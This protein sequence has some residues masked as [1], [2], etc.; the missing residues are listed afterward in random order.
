MKYV[1]GKNNGA[2][3]STGGFALLYAVLI[4]SVMTSIGLAIFNITTKEIILSSA[5]RESQ[6][7]F[8]AAD[9]GIECGLFWNTAPDEKFVIDPPSPNN[10]DCN[11]VSI[12]VVPGATLVEED[13]A[14]RTTTKNYSFA[15]PI[16]LATGSCSSV[17]V[18]KK[19]QQTHTVGPPPELIPGLTDPVVISTV[20][21]SRGYN[22]GYVAGPP[23]N[24][25]GPG[26]R[27]VERGIQVTF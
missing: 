9:T 12:I 17:E 5:A 10:I 23:S 4:A 2:Q 27:K 7:A 19:F 6:F 16:D 21:K 11:G 26:G 3:T 24:C 15:M 13:S 22:T 14:Y 18:E 25:G 8:Y 1:Y 20:I